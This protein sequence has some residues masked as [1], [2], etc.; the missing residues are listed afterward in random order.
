MESI[1]YSITLKYSPHSNNMIFCRVW[2]QQPIR[3]I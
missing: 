1:I 3:R 2:A